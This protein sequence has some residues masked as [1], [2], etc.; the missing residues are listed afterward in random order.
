MS[1]RSND[2]VP[3]RYLQLYSVWATQYYIDIAAGSHDLWSR[4]KKLHAASWLYSTI[5]RIAAPL[6]C[7]Q[8]N[9]VCTCLWSTVVPL[10]L[11][12]APC[13]NIITDYV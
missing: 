1:N 5:V 8:K 10:L 11:R 7:N 2:Y 13:V 6:R 3:C 9:M 4:T 12:G